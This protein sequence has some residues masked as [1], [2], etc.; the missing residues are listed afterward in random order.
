MNPNKCC[1]RLGRKGRWWDHWGPVPSHQDVLGD[2]WCPVGLTYIFPEAIVGTVELNF[3]FPV[4][5]FSGD[6]Y[7]VYVEGVGGDRLRRRMIIKAIRP[8]TI[9]IKATPPT[10]PP[11]IAPTFNLLLG[12]ATLVGTE[13]GVELAF[14]IVALVP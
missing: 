13:V 4:I 6:A 3:I 7:A 5:I 11:A 12:V 10:T 1:N 8:A 14:G 9:P 2:Q